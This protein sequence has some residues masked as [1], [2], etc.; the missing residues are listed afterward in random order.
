MSLWQVYNWLVPL[1]LDSF[2]H[3]K[4]SGNEFLIG[5]IMGLDN[6]VAIAMIPVVSRISDRHKQKTGQRKGLV[7]AGIIIA[8]AAC[9]SL[10]YTSRISA[11][12]MIGNLVVILLAMNL[13]RAPAV[14]LMPDIT[15]E[16]VRS[17]AK[18]VVNIMGGVGS[19]LGYLLLLLTGVLNLDTSYALF[20]VAFIMLCCLAVLIFRVDERKFERE[21]K[22]D[23]RMV[24]ENKRLQSFPFDIV[25]SGL[26]PIVLL[27]CR[28]SFRKDIA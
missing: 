28:A 12:I 8:A 11:W 21:I 1:Y 15:P 13:Y 24:G 20:G 9:V 17:K 3:E 25:F 22:L 6:L 10:A 26:L 2:L 16:P 14:A 5:L 23:V 19:E 4:F 27:C 18:A 7:I